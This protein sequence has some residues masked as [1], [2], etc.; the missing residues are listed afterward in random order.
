MPAGS[1]PVLFLHGFWHGS[2]CWSEVILRL[3][4]AGRRAAAVDMAGHGLPAAWPQCLSERSRAAKDVATEPS[5][6]AGIGLDEAGDLLVSQI[7]QV[8]GGEP[9]TVVAHSAGGSVATRAVQRM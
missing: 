1:T 8:G 9:V 3:T 6:V 7:R 5:P 4:A 2:W